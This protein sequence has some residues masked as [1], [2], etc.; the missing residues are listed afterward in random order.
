[1]V[2]QKLLDPRTIGQ[3][4]YGSILSRK[5]H[6]NWEL[7]CKRCGKDWGNHFAEDPVADCN[8]W[9]DDRFV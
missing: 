1:M 3:P 9:G 8:M 5:Y 4:R 7:V 2:K 6:A